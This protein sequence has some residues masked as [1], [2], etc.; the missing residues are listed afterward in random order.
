MKFVI[1]SSEIDLHH[2][3]D[4]NNLWFFFKDRN[5]NIVRYEELTKVVAI[6][7][8]QTSIQKKFILDKDR[9]PTLCQTLTLGT[10]ISEKIIEHPYFD[11]VI[12]MGKSTISSYWY[13][14]NEKIGSY[15]FTMLFVIPLDGLK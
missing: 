1:N 12:K 9:N 7:S 8:L 15:Y 3:V 2:D 4:V 13:K 10:N 11:D 5:S 14:C 6:N